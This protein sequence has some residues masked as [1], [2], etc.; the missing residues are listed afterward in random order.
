[1]SPETVEAMAELLSGLASFGLA[2][3]F[4]V[5]LVRYELRERRRNRR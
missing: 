4:V 3:F 2:A 1:M 5:L